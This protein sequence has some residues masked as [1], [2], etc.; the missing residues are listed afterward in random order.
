[1]SRHTDAVESDGEQAT[2][3]RAVAAEIRGQPVLLGVEKVEPRAGQRAGHLLRC[4]LRLL[5]I[6]CSEAIAII[7]I[8]SIKQVDTR[9][10]ER[11]SPFERGRGKVR[12]LASADWRLLRLLLL[13]LLLLSFLLR[14]RL[15][16][17]FF[18]G[19][20]AAHVH[21]LPADGDKEEAER[22]QHHA[23]AGARVTCA[24]GRVAVEQRLTH[25]GSEPGIEP[26]IETGHQADGAPQRRQH[27]RRRTLNDAHR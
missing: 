22:G 5:T 16:L 2:E 26:E 19:Q 27:H 9:K 20:L 17:L 7:F 14:L 11:R 13:L 12:T 24:R 1:M 6:L 25:H 4:L 21:R 10:L 3:L 18:G 23:Q 8:Q 15:L